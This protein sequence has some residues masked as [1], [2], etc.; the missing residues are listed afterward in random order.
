M[1][2]IEIPAEQL[3][4]VKE[5]YAKMEDSNFGLGIDILNKQKAGSIFNKINNWFS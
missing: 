5:E 3:K 2:N 4:F 1:A